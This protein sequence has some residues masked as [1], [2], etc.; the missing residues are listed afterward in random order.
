LASKSCSPILA[1]IMK[2]QMELAFVLARI[3]SR[4]NGAGTVNRLQRFTHDFFKPIGRSC[5]R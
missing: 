2:I 3:E 5:P 4:P 1:T